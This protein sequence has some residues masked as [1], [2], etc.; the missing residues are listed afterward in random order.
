MTIRRQARS[1]KQCGAELVGGRADRRYCDDDCRRRAYRERERLAR[2][3][4]SSRCRCRMSCANTSLCRRLPHRVGRPCATRNVGRPHA[5]RMTRARTVLTPGPDLVGAKT[6]VCRQ[7]RGQYRSPV[8][9]PLRRGFL[10]PGSGA[11][12]SVSVPFGVVRGKLVLLPFQPREYADELS[13]FG[14]VGT[15]MTNARCSRDGPLVVLGLGPT[16]HTGKRW[17]LLQRLHQ[18]VHVPR[19][20]CQGM[21]QH[22]P[23]AG[24]NVPR[25]HDAESSVHLHQVVATI[26]SAALASR[27]G[28]SLLSA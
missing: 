24:R 26:T 2:A 25:G 5:Q 9:A 3:H 1:C 13:L 14:S 7:L 23:R 4:S 27:A 20:H 11:S 16:S 6:S 21:G 17:S 18:P 8:E 22:L 12:S 10:L 28:P 19:R 15:G